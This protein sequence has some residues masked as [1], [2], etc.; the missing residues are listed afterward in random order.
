MKTTKIV[1]LSIAAVVVLGALAQEAH[2]AEV[3]QVVPPPKAIIGSWIE[4]ITPSG[5]GA[6]PPFKSL[7]T[8]NEDGTSVFSDQGGVVTNP[9]Q[10]LSAAVGTWT[11]LRDRTFAWTHLEFVSDLNGNL[12]GTA[13]I[14]GESIV[15][16]S[17][18]KYTSQI[19]IEVVNPNGQLIFSGQG[20][21]EA[22]RILIRRLQ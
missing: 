12:L 17:G 16:T 13:R 6:P 1:A 20:T 8:Y 10:V 11:Y 21:A 15:D 22:Q 7:G 14:W 18:N 2:A 4:T 9:P 5:P 3:P 19:R